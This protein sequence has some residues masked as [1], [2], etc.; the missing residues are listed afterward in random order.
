MALM[1]Q[2]QN[3]SEELSTVRNQLLEIDS[4]GQ[5]QQRMEYE[6]RERKYKHIIRE[7]K[8][9]LRTR[10]NVVPVGLY[11]SAVAEAKQRAAECH[12]HKEVATSLAMKIAKL[13]KQLVMR[14]EREA[15]PTP[16]PTPQMPH[17]SSAV[18]PPPPT[19]VVVDENRQQSQPG[20]APVVSPTQKTQ[21]QTIKKVRIVSP[22]NSA[23]VTSELQSF[24]ASSPVPVA[25]KTP[26]TKATRLFSP[27]T[28]KSADRCMM[29]TSVVRAAGG[30]MALQK[31]LRQMRSP[32]P[33]TNTTVEQ[34]Q[35]K[36]E[37]RGIRPLPLRE[38]SNH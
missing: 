9:Q 30:R 21:S 26:A 13:E 35:Q 29:R 7:M 15:V 24:G 2:I 5:V 36:L 8:E 3:L 20:T 32:K 12:S 31:K 17:L 23:V 33:V 28:P 25:T 1:A 11:R 38:K 19:N 27:F 6:E 4:S 16:S 34:C 18:A 22:K 14:G 37:Q 10:E